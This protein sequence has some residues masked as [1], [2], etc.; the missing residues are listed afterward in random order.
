MSI[1]YDFLFVAFT[2]TFV[3]VLLALLT[4]PINVLTEILIGLVQPA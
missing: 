4:V 1:F 3:G 2:D